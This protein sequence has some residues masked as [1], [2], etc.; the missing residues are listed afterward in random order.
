MRTP[1]H[2]F[3]WAIMFLLASCISEPKTDNG[4]TSP[5]LASLEQEGETSVQEEAKEETEALEEETDGDLTVE[6]LNESDVEGDGNLRGIAPATDIDIRN[7]L[8]NI[9]SLISSNS[10]HVMLLER[11]AAK[12]FGDSRFY[13]DKK[14]ISL[15]DMRDKE[16]SPA[17]HY[18]FEDM[19]ESLW[20]KRFPAY[21]NELAKIGLQFIV[22]EGMYIGLGPKSMGKELM[23]TMASVHLQQYEQFIDASTRARMGEYPYQNMG[24]YFD[25]LQIGEVFL[26]KG[27]SQLDLFAEKISD[28]FQSALATVTD[29]HICKENNQKPFF[30][31]D[32]NKDYFPYSTYIDDHKAFVKSNP[33]SKFAPI[34]SKIIEQPSSFSQR[35]ENIYLIVHSWEGS[36]NEAKDKVHR[37]LLSGMDVPHALPVVQGDNKIRYA[38]TYRFFDEERLAEKAMDACKGQ[39]I[40]AT[41]I[42]TSLRKGKLYQLGI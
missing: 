7:Q 37:L 36:R 28:D 12:F 41:M 5:D 20:E 32:L 10:E 3:L 14:W 4:Q 8:P 30:V 38:V 2:L 18:Y 23:R 27:D 24:P 22:A 42:F 9:Y 17:L 21:E 11:F 25:M 39:G 1:L 6:G 34:I 15:F 35:T 31:G 33:N 40:E 29:I 13:D 16:L 19:N 26:K